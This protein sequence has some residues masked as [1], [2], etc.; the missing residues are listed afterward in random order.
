VTGGKPL[1]AGSREQKALAVHLVNLEIRGMVPERA[2]L[3]PDRWEF[4]CECGACHE[5]VALSATEFDRNMDADE[6]ILAPGHLL[7]AA[8]ETRRTARRLREE[9]E[10]LRAQAQQAVRRAGITARKQRT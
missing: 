10:A 1:D 7:A 3:D 4:L 8:A 9:S 2:W 6:F 5:H